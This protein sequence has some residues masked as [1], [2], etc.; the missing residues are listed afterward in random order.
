MIA[1]SVQLLE[2]VPELKF[3]PDALGVYMA[4]PAPTSAKV[5][6]GAVLA[7]TLPWDATASTLQVVH[8][9]PSIYRRP[10]FDSIRYLGPNNQDCFARLVCLFSAV[11]GRQTRQLAFVRLYKVRSASDIL[12]RHKFIPLAWQL[13]T[14][15]TVSR[16]DTQLGS[17]QAGNPV[18]QVIPLAAIIC[19]EYVLPMFGSPDFFYVSPYKW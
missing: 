17:R 3:L 5:T 16:R 14:A 12:T 8:A 18:Y 1:R 13:T 9:S 2:Q 11:I 7:A 15:A 6:N 19:R 4:A 10:W